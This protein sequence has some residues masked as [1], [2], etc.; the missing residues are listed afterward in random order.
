MR[1]WRNKS[2]RPEILIN[3]P[4]PDVLQ[5][6]HRWYAQLHHEVTKVSDAVCEDEHFPAHPFLQVKS[7]RVS[8][9]VFSVHTPASFLNKNENEL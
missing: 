7:V 3:L 1:S 4:S 6:F 8:I 5:T 9:N 2:E